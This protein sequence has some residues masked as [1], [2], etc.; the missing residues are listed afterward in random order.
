MNVLITNTDNTTQDQNTWDFNADW[1][2][3][4]ELNILRG[5]Y[6]EVKGCVVDAFRK[7][8]LKVH[9]H[10]ISKKP[11]EIIKTAISKKLNCSRHDVY[12][13]ETTNTSWISKS[14]TAK[15][16]GVGVISGLLTVNNFSV[17]FEFN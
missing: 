3:E 2:S 12:E 4:K 15:V 9:A 1:I 8:E 10:E 5:D 6:S 16:D 7:A 11:Q 14:F 17:D 13:I